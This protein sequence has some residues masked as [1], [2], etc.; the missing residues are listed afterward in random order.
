MAEREFEVIVFGAGPAGE[1]AAGRAADTGMRTAT[2]PG[3]DCTNH[4]VSD[5]PICR[6]PD[7]RHTPG[8]VASGARGQGPVESRAVAAAGARRPPPKA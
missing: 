1:V 4:D 6:S 5:A 7:S 8:G 3:P 2:R